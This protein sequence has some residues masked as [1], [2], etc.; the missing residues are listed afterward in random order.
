MD[1]KVL[2]VVEAT[3]N[4]DNGFDMSIILPKGQPKLTV[5]ETIHFLTAGI[6]LLIKSASKLNFKDYELMDEV[7][8]HLNSEF[9]STKNDA[10]I[11]NNGFDE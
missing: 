11:L 8:K 7:F 9:V 4:L 2:I 1:N 10:E 6:C 3:Q 5:K